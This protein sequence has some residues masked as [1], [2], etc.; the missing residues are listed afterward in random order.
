MKTQDTSGSVGIR[1]SRP[2]PGLAVLARWLGLRF[3]KRSFL[4]KA[5]Y[6]HSI[7]YRAPC[8]PDGTSLPWMNYAIIAF[9]EERLNASLSV[10]EYGSGNS[11]LF[12]AKRV[13]HVVSVEKDPN[14]HEYVAAM[15][16]E[17]VELILCQ[18]YSPEAYLKVIGQ[19]D[20]RFDIVI[21][22]AEERRQCLMD[23]PRWLTPGGVVILDDATEDTY[24]HDTEA[25]AAKGFKRLVFE[26]MKPG[27]LNVYR[28][29]IFYRSD[30]VFDL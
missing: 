2:L 10:F 18:P 26:G 24:R 23:A 22:D 11:T 20:K 21:V 17:N 14:W 3:S 28:T 27:G 5:G 9:L 6:F 12:F 19:Q 1:L 13:D 25:L 4:R 8:R 7:R 16:P 30:N 15:M 29:A